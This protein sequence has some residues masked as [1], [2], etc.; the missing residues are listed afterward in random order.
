MGVLAERATPAVQ[1][2]Q[3]ARLG[4]EKALICTQLK[5]TLTRAVEQQAIDGCAVEGPQRDEVVWQCEDAMEVIAGQQTLQLLL[6]P[7]LTGSIGAGRA[8]AMT[9]RV[10]LNTAVVS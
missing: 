6:Q 5:Q 7:L 8:T 9:T 3:Q 2:H 1:C 10:V 4:A